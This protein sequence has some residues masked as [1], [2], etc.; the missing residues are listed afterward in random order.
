MN[1]L[2]E[3]LR[4]VFRRKEPSDGF[5]DRVMVRIRNASAGTEKSERA[6]RTWF[7]PLRFRWVAAAAML[8]LLLGSGL[9]RYQ[10]VQQERRAG[11]EARQQLL[12][13]LQITGSKFQQIHRL[14]QTRNQ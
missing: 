12:L 5:A 2:E 10:Q 11:E 7:L 9:L 4:E 14:L 13:A 6:C 1:R 3:E 8:F